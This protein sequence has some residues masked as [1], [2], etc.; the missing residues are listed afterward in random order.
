MPAFQHHKVEDSDADSNS[1]SE[2]D[3]HE[4]ALA[5][6]LN[7]TL[8]LGDLPQYQWSGKI[9]RPFKKALL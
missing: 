8:Q 4:D 1:S 5:P 9:G 7:E 6:H 2:A 3:E